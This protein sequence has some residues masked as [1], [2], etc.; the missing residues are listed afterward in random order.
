MI[1]VIY[2]NENCIVINK[3]VGT[4]SLS[5]PS[6]DADALTLTAAQL[7]SELWPVHRLDRTV[8]GLMVLAKNKKAAAT[9]S[10]EVGGHGMV[11]EYFAVVEGIAEGGTYEDYIYRDARISKAFIVKGERRGAKHASLDCT[12][13]RTVSTERGERT[14]LRILLHTGRYHQIRVQLASRGNSIV[15]D[16]KYGSRDNGAKH[17]ALF[18]AHLTFTVSGEKITAKSKPDLKIY[19]WSL[20]SE[21]DYE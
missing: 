16:G 3:P 2:E 17:P 6:G 13:I 8:G 18:S 1:D 21:E 9:L 5:D 14:L 7:G 15:G 19:P 10:A 12:P 20:F 11:K 4:P